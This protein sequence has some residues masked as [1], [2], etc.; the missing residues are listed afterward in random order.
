MIAASLA[1]VSLIA[2]LTIADKAV[3]EC[4]GDACP[5][6][7]LVASGHAALALA[8]S[9][10]ASTLGYETSPSFLAHPNEPSSSLET[11]WS[12]IHQKTRLDI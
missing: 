2:S 3:H 10:G 5:L 9:E 12:L 1:L 11:C 6:C 4:T 7:H 8:S